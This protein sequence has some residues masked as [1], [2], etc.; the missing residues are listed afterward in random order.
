IMNKARYEK[1]SADE[2]KAIDALSGETAARLFGQAWDV[3]DQ[4]GMDL[5]KTNGVQITQADA[6]FIQ[7]IRTRVLPV[8]RQWI[9]NAKAKG[10][11]D[12]AK[13]LEAL[14]AEVAK[15]GR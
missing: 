10:L 11:S 5:M 3:A 9:E 4:R 1:L 2:K 15:A 14:R 12:P 6:A 7:D 13:V 8:E